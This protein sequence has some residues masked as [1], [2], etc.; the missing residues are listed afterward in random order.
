[1]SIS[2]SDREPVVYEV[3][4]HRFHSVR[5]TVHRTVHTYCTYIHTTITKLELEGSSFYLVH[6]GSRTGSAKC[7]GISIFHLR[8]CGVSN[9]AILIRI[10]DI[11]EQFNNQHH[12]YLW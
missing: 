3:K 5:T 4:T 10:H 6:S 7:K 1:M 12:V 11:K 8:G 2:S 9:P